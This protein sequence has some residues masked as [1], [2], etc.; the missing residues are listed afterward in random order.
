MIRRNYILLKSKFL[1]LTLIILLYLF[2]TTTGCSKEPDNTST[3]TDNDILPTSANDKGLICFAANTLSDSFLNSIDTTLNEMFTADGYV[4]MSTSSENDVALQ[5]NQIENF[6]TMG[7]KCILTCASPVS[8]IKE[9]CI[10]AIEKGTYIVFLGMEPHEHDGFEVSGVVNN[11]N[12]EVG[13]VVG[14]MA[15][16]WVNDT[17]PES[18]AENPIKAA[19]FPLTLN[20]DNIVRSEAIYDTINTSENIDIVYQFEGSSITVDQ[21]YNYAENAITFDAQI[22]LFVSFSSSVGIGINNYVISNVTDDY[23]MY[24]AFASDFTEDAAKLVE[25]SVDG[26][27]ILRGIVNYGDGNPA[28]SAYECITALITGVKPAPY[29]L[30]DAT[31]PINSVG[32]I[33][34]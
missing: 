14:G 32:Y 7:A 3:F 6:V 12:Q 27:S 5:I 8:S 28:A 31:K 1:F 11:N 16:K 23:K 30:Y 24:A 22:R 9:A 15:I 25:Q 34:P 10:N 21:G 17:Y 19:V 26:H 18:D 20:D 29:Y 4:Y 33:L 13:E 2:T